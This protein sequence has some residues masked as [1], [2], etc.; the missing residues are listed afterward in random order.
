[1]T[2]FGLHWLAS[3][4]SNSISPFGRFVRRLAYP[5]LVLLF[6][7]T[8]LI[9]ISI[10]LGFQ[11]ASLL[12]CPPILNDEIHYW[13]EIA[14]FAHA[15]FNGG[16][17]V[18]NER[19]APCSFSHFGPH[20]PAFP[21]IFGSLGY[22]F[23][24]HSSSG[25]QFNILVLMIA[26]AC[27]V[28]FCRPNASRL[29]CATLVMATF[30]PYLLFLQATMQEALNHAIA[31]LLAGVAYAGLRSDGRQYPSPWLFILAVTAVS[32]VRFTWLLVLIPWGCVLLLRSTWRTRLLAGAAIMAVC[33]AVFALTRW[34]SAPYPNF[35][36]KLMET[37]RTTPKL[38]RTEFINHAITSA[39]RF[40]SPS[41]GDLLERLQHFEVIGLV[42]VGV[43]FVLA[44][45]TGRRPHFFAAMNLALIGGLMI[46]L[47]DIEDWRDYRVIAP[48]ILFSLLIL[49]S[50]TDFRVPLTV[51]LIH[52]MFLNPFFNL[53]VSNNVDRFL[54][55]Q[56]S[57]DPMRVLFE[58][59]LKYDP[60][61]SPWDNTLLISVRNHSFQL[62][63]VPPGIG[64]SDIM[65]G[66]DVQSLVFPLKSR[67]VL[68]WRGGTRKLLR[69][70]AHLQPLA[71][72]NMGTLYLNLDC[73]SEK[74]ARGRE[75]A[76][77]QG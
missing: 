32:L 46:L 58:R 9:T 19:P 74:R 41:S 12:D 51:A 15:G 44:R 1:V 64:I 43:C 72:T 54:I 37:A 26:S 23:G 18:P 60:Q 71:D 5:A 28:A 66:L 4:R 10:V 47:Y 40:I 11:K 13:N 75:R 57:I 59:E 6:L 69:Y 76:N 55:K 61:A 29:A 70:K 73:Q 16:Y 36:S 3:L 77:D 42:L 27:W 56:T 63:A 20:G 35:A 7:L 39:Q 38:A 65:E 30:W 53:H 48:H 25:P 33:P 34:L 67:Y 68:M 22:V 52:L 24:W 21:V 17:S 31:V 50:T 2:G 8:P 45:P 62:T 14:T 49:V